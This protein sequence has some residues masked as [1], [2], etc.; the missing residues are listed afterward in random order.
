RY[1]RRSPPA[2]R[3][4][5][6]AFAD[7]NGC[8]TESVEH[9]ATVDALDLGQPRRARMDAVVGRAWQTEKVTLALRVR[10]FFWLV[11]S[12]ALPVAAIVLWGA[13]LLSAGHVTLGA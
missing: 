9:A 6:A 2:Y 11:V 4:N 10:V 13:H 8:L 1:L 3:E 5:A 12:F 7:L